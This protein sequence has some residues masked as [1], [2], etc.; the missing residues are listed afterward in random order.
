MFGI[1]SVEIAEKAID[2]IRNNLYW[3]N[4]SVSE[5]AIV[6]LDKY[7][8]FYYLKE[9]G[10]ASDEYLDRRKNYR[11]QEFVESTINDELWKL[12]EQAIK[13]D[14]TNCFDMVVRGMLNNLDGFQSNNIKY[15]KKHV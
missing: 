2:L 7:N 12:Q 8:W 9:I 13:E 15:Y 3:K 10:F 11:P 5:T 4:K 14:P 6:L 1:G